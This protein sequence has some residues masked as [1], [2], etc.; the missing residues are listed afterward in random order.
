MQLNLS[1]I[2]PG[3]FIQLT[4]QGKFDKIVSIDNLS[5]I[6]SIDRNSDILVDLRKVEPFNLSYTDI[7][8]IVDYMVDHQDAFSH[9]I[10]V[11]ISLDQPRKP[12]KF[13]EKFG[14]RRGLR[15]QVFDNYEKAIE[16]LS[17]AQTII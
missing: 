15:I 7:V 4:P 16:W 13:L 10:A 5:R 12:D 9:K 8:D 17:K 2:Y 14:L 6:V 3:E 1:L 11:L